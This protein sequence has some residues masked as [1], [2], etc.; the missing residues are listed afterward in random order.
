MSESTTPVAARGLGH[1]AALA[2]EVVVS[3]LTELWAHKM[4]SILTLTLLML[5]VFALVVMTSVLDGILDKIGTG[6]SGMSWDGTLVMAPKTPETSDEQKRFAMSPGL[7]MEDVPRLTAPYDKVMAFMP[8]SVKQTS[9]RVA[10][11]N[12]RIMVSGNVPDYIPVMNRKIASGRGLTEDDQKRRSTVAVLGASLASKFLGGADPVGKDI[13][14]DGIPFRVVGVLAPLMIF[15][16]DS[17]VDANGMLIPLEAYMDRLDPTH[18][19]AQ[20]GVKLKAKRD[21]KD[22]TALVLGRAKQAHHGIEDVEILDL[23]AEAA[24]SW[25]NFMQ[26]MRGWTIV[27]MSLAGT[28]L[29]V[30]G[31]GVLSVMLI[32]FSDRRYE[33]GL[34]KALGASDQE[35]FVQFLLE[36]A[37]L[38]ALGAL[39]GTL[40]GAALCKALSA[41]FPY[42]LVVNMY[43]LLMAWAVALALSLVFGMYPAFRAMRL[44]PMEAMR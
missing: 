11:G 28:V 17:W 12:E 1:Q 30:G 21:A 23:D 34:R 36:A 4:R 32:S 39:T 14:V 26:Q 16:E 35:I 6:F 25:Q 22:V 40:A 27:L 3:G 13:M 44:S 7:R 42:G 31:V 37:V 19:L 43:G 38:A 24:R 20:L 29:L 10:G 9:V 5:G 33:I 8:R 15:N 18:K 41:N 2:W